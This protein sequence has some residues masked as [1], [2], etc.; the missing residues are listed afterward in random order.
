MHIE[1]L[2]EE[3]SAEA[4]LAGVLPKLLPESVSWKFHLF[5]GKPD[6]LKQLESRLKG[7]RAWLPESHRIVVLVDE[8]RQDCKKLKAQLEKAAKNAGLLT[9]TTAGAK[10]RF[11]VLNRIAVEEIEAW[12]IGD[13][14]ALKAA[15]PRLPASFASRS[16]YRSPDAISGGTAEALER[17][18]QTSGY[19]KAGMPKIEVARKV[20]VFL[21]PDINKSPSFQTFAQGL[22][23]L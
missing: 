6:L 5:Q 7:Y 22:S 14:A 2:L 17:L 18:L 10:Q 15:F 3:P 19:Y 13:P 16:K 12:M 21:Q 9:K 8:D 11:V 23:R 1:F 20:G 4:L